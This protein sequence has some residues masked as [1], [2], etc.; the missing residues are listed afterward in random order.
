MAHNVPAVNEGFLRPIKKNAK[1]FYG[2]KKLW[3]RENR[4]KGVS[5]TA[6][7]RSPSRFS[8]EAFTVLLCAALLCIVF[9]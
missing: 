5:P 9:T 3:R 4:T 2:R 6:V 1:H 8:G 7:F